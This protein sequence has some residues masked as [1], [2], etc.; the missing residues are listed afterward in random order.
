MLDVLAPEKN[1]DV[2]GAVQVQFFGS[3]GADQPVI[4][5]NSSK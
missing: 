5:G 4:G 1:V 2:C 3:L